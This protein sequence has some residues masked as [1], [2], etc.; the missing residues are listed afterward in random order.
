MLCCLESAVLDALRALTATP[1]KS[2]NHFDGQR[3]GDLCLPYLV[4]K[5][6]S[7]GG[8]RTSSGNFSS[9]SVE[10]NAYFSDQAEGTAKSYKTLVEAWLFAKGCLDLGVCGCFCMQGVPVSSIRPAVAG[11]VVYSVTFR[12]FYKPSEEY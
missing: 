9:H 8:L 7:S 12:G 4:L 1:I 2:S 6:G 11:T 5:T 3:K 10:F